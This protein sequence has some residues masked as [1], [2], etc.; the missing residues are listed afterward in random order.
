MHLPGHQCN[1]QYDNQIF[2]V[3]GELST[4]FHKIFGHLYILFCSLVCH[5]MRLCCIMF[6]EA[7]LTSTAWDWFY[8]NFFRDVLQV[9]VNRFF[10][11]IFNLFLP[12]KCFYTQTCNYALLRKNNLN[13]IKEKSVYNF[14][15]YCCM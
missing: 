14:I 12:F 3:Q 6:T 2:C 15:K 5:F 8:T 1:L 10:G 13:T 4:S 11:I 9:I 7:F